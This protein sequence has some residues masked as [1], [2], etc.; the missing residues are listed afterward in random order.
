LSLEK[1]SRAYCFS[2]FHRKIEDKCLSYRDFRVRA[3]PE[4]LCRCVLAGGA[5]CGV[6]RIEW[7]VNGF[8]RAFLQSSA[9]SFGTAVQNV[10]D[11]YNSLTLQPVSDIPL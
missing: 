11:E 10:V 2:L 4:Y 8:T 7:K 9:S 5:R 6:V 3:L 1:R